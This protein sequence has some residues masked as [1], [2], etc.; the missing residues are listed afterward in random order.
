MKFFKL[1][2][3]AS[4]A[5]GA[6]STAS[7]AQPLEEAIKGVD[8]KGY[9]RY[10]YTDDRY[11]NQKFVKND[12]VVDKD[13][14][15]SIAATRG[16]AKHE[17]RGQVDFKTPTMNAISVNLGLLYKDSNDTNH[18]K[19]G[20]YYGKLPSAQDNSFNLRTLYLNITPDSTATDI[21]V[22]KQI[23]DTPITGS[24]DRGVGFLAFNRDIAGLTL[25]LGAF[26]TWSIDDLSKVDNGF[27]KPFYT[28]AAIY[29]A[30][31]SIGNIGAQAWGFVID[32]IVDAS[33]FLELSWKNSLLNAKLQYAFAKLENGD[34]SPIQGINKTPF[35]GSDGKNGVVAS[36][37]GKGGGLPQ[38][39]DVLS[40]QIGADFTKDFNVPFNARL[41]YLTNFKDGTVALLDSEGELAK[42]G[43][44]WFANP[45]T[46][47]NFGLGKGLSGTSLYGTETDL[48]VFYGAIG[49]GLVDGR[50]KLG[51]EAAFGEN[52]RSWTGDIAAKAGQ[53]ADKTKF[54]EVTPTISWKYNKNLNLSAYY[55]M[56]STE[57]SV[58]KDDS[59]KKDTYADEDRNRLRLEARYSF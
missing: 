17:W 39:N 26:D 51:L 50:L 41:G 49:Y 43:K 19:V 25:A 40:F 14:K 29:S 28:L 6:F 34:G 2:L 23:L 36:V 5:L 31:S 3:A 4:V 42:A 30:D 1:S 21:R 8:V 32:D 18:G 48:E 57:N 56:L 27:V 47:V 45:A 35:D 38:D 59:A 7:F 10:R 20:Q 11:D 46:A 53:L 55:A 13:T 52:K 24:D 15:K 9:L 12:K 16:S 54:T 33:A 37:A 22:G 44:I 58:K